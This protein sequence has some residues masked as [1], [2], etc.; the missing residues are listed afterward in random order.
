MR[1]IRVQIHGYEAVCARCQ[2]RYT[3]AAVLLRLDGPS[4]TQM[5][6][7]CGLDDPDLLAAARPLLAAAGH[8]AAEAIAYRMIDGTI[9]MANGCPA[10]GAPFGGESAGHRAFRDAITEAVTADP[11]LES[12]PVLA[13][14]NLPAGAI[15]NTHSDFAYNPN[16]DL[17]ADADLDATWRTLPLRDRD[18]VHVEILEQSPAA[19]WLRAYAIADDQE[20]ERLARWPWRLHRIKTRLPPYPTCLG[21][22][23]EHAALQHGEAA[24]LLVQLEQDEALVWF[25]A[26]NTYA[27]NPDRWD[28]TWH[29]SEVLTEL[30]Q[31]PATT[32]M[33]PR[34][35]W[36]HPHRVNQLELFGE[37]FAEPDGT[38]QVIPLTEPSVDAAEKQ[39]RNL[40]WETLNGWTAYRADTFDVGRYE[41]WVSYQDAEKG[42][43]P[44]LGL[45]DVA[46]LIHAKNRRWAIPDSV[47]SADIATAL[48]HQ[49][50]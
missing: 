24:Q 39:L 17:D 6:V 32:P 15:T 23:A 46:W 47:T 29:I 9:T 38:R 12:L 30:D 48:V 35:A 10:C 18:T 2:R 8:P 45:A 22:V 40:G 50:S 7:V 19:R 1:T 27:V 41:A 16:P 11:T 43:T 25:S 49:Q 36:F 4:F 3:P 31:V 34:V 14:G 5:P 28:D 44:E 21:A 13:T 33:T 26:T 42:F 20:Q 37:D